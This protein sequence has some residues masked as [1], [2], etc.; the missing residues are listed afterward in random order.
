VQRVR[1]RG[2]AGAVLRGRGRAMRRLRRGGA[3]RQQARREAPAGAAPD[4]LRH[5]RRLPRAGRAQVRHLSG[6]APSPRSSLLPSSLHPCS[7]I[8]LGGFG[9]VAH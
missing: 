7:W 2:G 4:G 1:G 9:V 3:R 5:R 8:G 6:E